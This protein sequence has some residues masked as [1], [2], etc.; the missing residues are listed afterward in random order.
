M[1]KHK[2]KYKRK[3]ILILSI[4]A[5]C[6]VSLTITLGKYVIE[7]V[8]DFYLRTKEF[9][10]YSDK[11]KEDGAIYEI[12]NWSGVDSYTITINMNSMENNLLVA[13][14]DISYDIEY[15]CSSNAIC[16]LSKTRGIIDAE[17]NNDTFNVRITPNTQLTTGDVV[18]VKVTA[19]ADAEYEKTITAEFSLVVGIEDL[20]YTIDDSSGSPYLEIDIT[21]TLS[22]YTVRTAFGSYSV[23]DTIPG[24]TY[25][26][27]SDAEKDNC[28]SALVT[29]EFDTDKL[30]IDT[31]GKEYQ[32]AI[33]VL[34]QTATDSYTNNTYKV[35]N[36][37]TLAMEAV[38]STTVRLYKTDI[39]A[40]YTDNT[41]ETII[42]VTSQ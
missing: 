12:N 2:V 33:E 21:N 6:C 39:S 16:Q 13:S 18:W 36:S 19:I 9:Y 28:Y 26:T 24:E 37:I 14:Y 22:Y 40:D 38:S 31:A 15:E 1:K 23:G 32:E 25:L 5:I 11:L 29:I 30:V 35:I 41:D 3:Q 8:N 4:L 17:T 27:L 20:T 34:T 42:K 7:K 10:F